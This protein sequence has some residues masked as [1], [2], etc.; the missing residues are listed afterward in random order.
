MSNPVPGKT[1]TIVQGDTLSGIASRAY[2]DG[3]KF[4]II[5][6]ANQ[7]S[8]RSGDEDLIFPGEIIFIPELVEVKKLQRILSSEELP[9]KD[10]D[11]FTLIIDGL[12]VPVLSGKLM[13]TMDTVS[14]GFT[15][16]ISWVPG[17]DPRLDQKI[18]PFTYTK[19]FI[20]LGGKLQLSGR[21]YGTEPGLTTSGTTKNFEG[22]SFTIDL[23][24][25]H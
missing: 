3:L 25:I 5:L 2:G 20:Y 21:I 13:L 14:D 17:A 23:V 24:D 7:S 8:L 12:E 22:W 6:N 11:D 15:A 9:N 18:R 4:P 1:Y 16:S 19:A 10:L